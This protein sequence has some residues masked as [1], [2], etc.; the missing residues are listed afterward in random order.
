VE[1]FLV[2]MGFTIVLEIL[3]AKGKA[4]QFEAVFYKIHGAIE[5]VFPELKPENRDAKGSDA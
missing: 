3:R 4:K 5:N 2:Q 1:V